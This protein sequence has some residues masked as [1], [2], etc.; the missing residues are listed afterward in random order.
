MI[1][2]T[3]DPGRVFCV[4]G[5][6][7][8]EAPAAIVERYS[9]PIP[10]TEATAKPERPTTP[11]AVPVARQ[12]SVKHKPTPPKTV[13]KPRIAPE[14]CARL[15]AEGK[16]IQEIAAA[17]GCEYRSTYHFLRKAGVVLPKI[18]VLKGDQFGGLTVIRLL[19]REKG[20]GR[21]FLCQCRCGKTTE[22]PLKGLRSSGRTSCG[23]AVPKRDPECVRRVAEQFS[24]GLGPTAIARK[25]GMSRTSVSNIRAELRKASCESKI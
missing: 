8:P 25:L 19:R 22:A 12:P 2:Y 11:R 5:Q 10:Y 6:F 24:L 14:E 1:E 3:Q 7:T 23:C 17:V 13:A 18:E 15:Y 4:D 21:V 16:T 9:Q 20:K